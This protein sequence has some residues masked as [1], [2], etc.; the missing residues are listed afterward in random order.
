MMVMLGPAVIQALR[1]A[2][3]PNTPASLV[4]RL[5]DRGDREAWERFVGLYAPLI[6]GYGRRRGLQDADAAD[7]TQAV[8]Q[9]VVGS[10]ERYEYDPAQARF[11]TWL[12]R[13]VRNQFWRLFAHRWQ[14]PAEE[15]GPEADARLRECADHENE[16]EAAEWEQDYRRGRFRWAAEQVRGGFEESSWRA[17]WH[18]A[19]DGRP[20]PDVA[21]ELGLSVG[22]VYTAKSRV[23]ER[24]RRVIETV[25]D[26]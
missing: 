8:L 11:H 25:Q 17:F 14:C 3:R 22:A 6:Y 5:R 19:V 4:L 20:A 12:F 2:G 21:S 15:Q 18:T 1:M 7:L 10:I 16:H 23:L 24:I 9:A 13:V 26:D